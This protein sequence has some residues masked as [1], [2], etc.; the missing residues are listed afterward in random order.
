MNRLYLYI[1]NYLGIFRR[2]VSLVDLYWVLVFSLLL[3][4]PAAYS[5]EHFAK[6]VFLLSFLHSFSWSI[7]FCLLFR[8]HYMRVIFFLLLMFLF[9]IELFCAFKLGARFSSN[10]M[11]LILQTN[12]EEIHTF[13]TNYI[14][15]WETFI[16]IFSFLTLCLL[17]SYLGKKLSKLTI[18][19]SKFLFTIIILIFVSG[20]SLPYLNI[21]IHRWENSVLNC[22][23]SGAFIL[24]RK[25]E[26]SH[27]REMYKG[28]KISSSPDKNNAPIIT[29]ILGESF[30]KHYSNLY[31]Y[32]QNT[33]PRLLE[34]KNAGNL[35]LFENA[36]TPTSATNYA[37]KYI[38]THKE[39]IP[40]EKQ[41]SCQYILFPIVLKKS[42][43]KVAYFD[44]Q[45]EKHGGL[46]YEG[47]YFLSPSDISEASFDL[48]SEKIYKYDEDFIDAYKNK[49]FRDSKSFNIIHLYGQ[50]SMPR[51]PQEFDKFKGSDIQSD[52]IGE[53]E[54]ELIA[55]YLNSTLYN[56]HVVN[57][58]MESMRDYNSVI[59]YV[60]DHGECVYNGNGVTYGRQLDNCTD[61]NRRKNTYEIP[62]MI[63][64]SDSYK[65]YNKDVFDR[66]DSA[67]LRTFCL[68]DIPY[69]IYDLAGV[70]FNYNQSHKSIISPLFIPHDIYLDESFV[71]PVNP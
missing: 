63:W 32:S 56:D 4:I 6:F 55:D 19:I 10:T 41:D 71:I 36:W 50:H 45:Y 1:C 8:K 34:W 18:K 58:I 46:D 27:I 3:S 31:G 33:N 53:N 65:M 2:K 28:I 62:M 69:L 13:F 23:K 5:K 30:N 37:M 51:F 49:I 26:F 43:Y 48:R 14:W 25:N 17:M 67:R 11:L 22:I 60:P 64:C 42:G 52:S 29:L 40:I 35:I 39:C 57:K 66:I 21:P 15:N 38:F 61:L 20:L 59:V 68:A 54:K 44:N 24:D 16:F 70:D 12:S 7:V 9:I 47:N